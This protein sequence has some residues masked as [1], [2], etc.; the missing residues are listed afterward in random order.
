[1]SMT[2]EKSTKLLYYEDYCFEIIVQTKYKKL[3]VSNTPDVL[4]KYCALTENT[5]SA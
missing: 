2:Y 3:A 4:K 5:N 1:M